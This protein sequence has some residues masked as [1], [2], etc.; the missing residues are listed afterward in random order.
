MLAPEE[1]HGQLKGSRYRILASPFYVTLYA[2][3]D[4]QVKSASGQ[5]SASQASKPAIRPGPSSPAGCCQRF[6]IPTVLD[7]NYSKT[8]VLVKHVEQ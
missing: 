8:L 2:G 1:L 4:S 5:G 3:H 6:Q 7:C